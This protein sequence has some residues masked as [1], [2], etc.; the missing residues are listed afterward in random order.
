M[1]S[2]GRN[3]TDELMDALAGIRAEYMEEADLVLRH[4]RKG[5]GRKRLAVLLAAA[6][7]LIAAIGIGVVMIIR[8]YTGK[9][10]VSTDPT[11]SDT[12]QILADSEIYNLKPQQIAGNSQT[13]CYTK[14]FRR[15]FQLLMTADRRTGISAPACS[16]EGCNHDN[17]S[18]SAFI[19]HGNTSISALSISESR[20]YYTKG[21]G[22]AEGQTVYSNDLTTGLSEEAARVDNGNLFPEEISYEHWNSGFIEGKDCFYDG[23]FYYTVCM[24]NGKDNARETVYYPTVVRSPITSG[25]EERTILQEQATGFDYIDMHLMPRDEGLYIFEFME[26]QGETLGKDYDSSDRQVTMYI[27]LYRPD[28][29]SAELVFSKEY[30]VNFII[31]NANILNG[32]LCF[33]SRDDTAN[34]C[35]YMQDLKGEPEILLEVKPDTETKY[36]MISFAKEYF[37]IW[38][39]DRSSGELMLEIELYNYEGEMIRNFPVG[40]PS[41]L[42][43]E[44]PEHYLK[45]DGSI[46]GETAFLGADSDNLY[47]RD[48]YYSSTLNDSSYEEFVYAVSTDGMNVLPFTERF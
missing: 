16:E 23:D 7:V 33:V 8:N 44:E 1:K 20:I 37:C 18:C 36:S 11:G 34:N 30:P 3:N 22:N 10:A 12:R 6:A 9:P 42:R 43:P 21:V 24:G 27:Y 46:S 4:G 28:E 47:F 35:V 29:D 25:R 31:S 2:N 45:E 40:K 39:Q 19:M 14:T 13:L 48:R 15:N 5:Q 41:E 38:Y 26:K 17:D 32:K